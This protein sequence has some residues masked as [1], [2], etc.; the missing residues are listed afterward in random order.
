MEEFKLGFLDGWKS[1][2][3]DIW[4]G[5]RGG[6]WGANIGLFVAGTTGFIGPAP[7]RA[8]RRLAGTGGAGIELAKESSD[9]SELDLG[10]ETLG[11]VE[12]GVS[13]ML[14]EEPAFCGALAEVSGEG[15]VEDLSMVVAVTLVGVRME[16]DKVAVGEEKLHAG[17]VAKRERGKNK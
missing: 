9:L 17:R 3:F 4:V 6:V 5:C 16:E 12:V 11:S 7:P 14:E 8:A 15:V 10:R 1:W 2:P 13:R